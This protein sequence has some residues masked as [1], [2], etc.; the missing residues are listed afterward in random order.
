MEIFESARNLANYISSLDKLN[1]YISRNN[2]QPD[3]IGSLI[4]DIVLQS[5]LSYN[6]VV[7]PRVDRILIKYPEAYNVKNLNYVIENYGLDEFLL[8]KHPIKLERF[9]LF[10]H[11]CL[12]KKINTCDD[13]ICYLKKEINRSEILNLKGFGYKTLDYLMKLLNFD[14]IAVDR[15]II[16]FVESAGLNHYNY[17]NTK[18]T[19]E[20]AADLLN[21]SRSSLDGIIWNYMS[22]NDPIVFDTSQ[23]RIQF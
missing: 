4:A 15:H 2:Y 20:Y 22:T 5:G 14:T 19:V 13:L 3:H 6:N 12:E 9:E 7:R 18:K 8:W 11:F 1:L 23:L 10:L 21:I 16:G 17:L